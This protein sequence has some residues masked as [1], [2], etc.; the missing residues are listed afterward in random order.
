M[1]SPRP[2][3]LLAG[4]PLA[5]LFIFACSGP[6]AEWTHED[7]ASAGP[8]AEPPSIS[9]AQPGAA[10]EAQPPDESDRG[11]LG[12]GGVSGLALDCGGTQD[13]AGGSC[14]PTD[15]QSACQACVA[16]SCCVEQT[17]CN[18]VDPMNTCAFGSTLFDGRPI[19][20]GEIG[21]LMECLTSRTS[22]GSFVDSETALALCSSRCA[23]S[24]CGAGRASSVSE[25]L[26]AC[27][28]GGTAPG[29]DGC[30]E[31]CGLTP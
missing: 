31:P 8:S 29:D 1:A 26:A 24:E 4:T 17:A 5:W 16:R 23:A 30:R 19:E 22:D 10:A 6:N 12:M 25:A 3:S 14:E 7:V 21:C 11:A 27:I 20:G 28:L 18:S 9:A 13:P 2:L 15:P